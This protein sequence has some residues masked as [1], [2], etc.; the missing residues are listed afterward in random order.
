MS[1]YVTSDIK[2]MRIKIPKSEFPLK[3][4]VVTGY[5]E[6]ILL[7]GE[8][9]STYLK[10]S[11]DNFC[12]SGKLCFSENHGVAIEELEHLAKKYNGTLVCDITGE[13][14]EIEYIRIRDGIRKKVKIVEED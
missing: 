14:G 4:D 8:G 11:D 2:E 7:Y 10:S 1:Y 5:R 13:D 12:I 3:S 6:P 9:E